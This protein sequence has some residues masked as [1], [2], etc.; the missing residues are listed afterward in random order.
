MNIKTFVGNG[1]C[2]VAV[3]CNGKVDRSESAGIDRQ[4]DG[5]IPSIQDP[6]LEGLLA[7]LSSPD[8]K[9][10]GARWNILA[11]SDTQLSLDCGD[12]SVWKFGGSQQV[13]V[14]RVQRTVSLDTLGDKGEHTISARFNPATGRVLP[15][16]IQESFAPYN[17]AYVAM[18][19]DMY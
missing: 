2:R 5:F 6:R 4:A 7:K 16:T 14:D 3:H 11:N 9:L 15:G 12:Q 8:S 1:G 19:R 10:L 13:E 18:M 17:S